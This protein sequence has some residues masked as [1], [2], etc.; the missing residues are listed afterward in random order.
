M[1]SLGA[2]YQKPSSFE[3]FLDVSISWH[4]PRFQVTKIEALSIRKN[5]TSTIVVV[6]MWMRKSCF[7]SSAMFSC[8]KRLKE[9]EGRTNSHV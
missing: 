4:L 9:S 8:A 5:V 1:T 2:L 6:S 3:I 7:I